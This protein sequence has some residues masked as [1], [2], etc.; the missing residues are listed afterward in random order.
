M[1][2]KVISGFVIASKAD[3]SEPDIL[4]D[5][6]HPCVCPNCG[7]SKFEEG[8]ERLIEIINRSDVT[9]IF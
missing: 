7:V 2:E 1:K 4:V 8:H 6:L 5:E 3:E 9:W